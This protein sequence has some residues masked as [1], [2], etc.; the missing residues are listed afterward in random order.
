MVVNFLPQR[1]KER[2]RGFKHMVEKIFKSAHR[3]IP[4]GCPN[5]NADIETFHNLVEND[6]FD[7][8]DFSSRQDFFGKFS[9]YQF[10]FN[11]SEKELL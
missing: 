1:Y 2:D 11:I 9:T 8:E 10:Y 3:L 5:A 7:L 4:L 6:F